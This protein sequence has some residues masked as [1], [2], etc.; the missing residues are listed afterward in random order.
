MSV[1]WYHNWRQ[2]NHLKI[3]LITSNSTILMGK[4]S[5]IS[6]SIVGKSKLSKWKSVSLVEHRENVGVKAKSS[7]PRGKSVRYDTPWK[8]KTKKIF[9]YIYI[10]LYYQID[11]EMKW[12][13]VCLPGT[14]R[15]LS[16]IIVSS[17][18]HSQ[19]SHLINLLLFP[20]Q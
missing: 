14:Q 17:E 6:I 9:I 8:S 13:S 3:I 19:F 10:F 2:L 12:K 4:K 11:I 15:T 18:K 1:H 20:L 16:V 7:E 5:L